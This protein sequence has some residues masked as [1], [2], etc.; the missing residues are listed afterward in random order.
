[1]LL[2]NAYDNENTKKIEKEK[3]AISR[4]TNKNGI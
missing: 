1:M 4:S 2:F 3:A